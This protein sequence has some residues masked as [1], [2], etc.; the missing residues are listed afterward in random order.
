MGTTPAF[1]PIEIRNDSARFGGTMFHF[2]KRGRPEGPLLTFVGMSHPQWDADAR[3]VTKKIAWTNTDLTLVVRDIT[4]GGE[5]KE[6][7]NP[8]KQGTSIEFTPKWGHK[9]YTMYNLNRMGGTNGEASRQAMTWLS[10]ASHRQY[11][12]GLSP[13]AFETRACQGFPS[14]SAR[15]ETSSG[16]IAQVWDNGGI[17]VPLRDIDLSRGGQALTPSLAIHRLDSTYGAVVHNARTVIGFY[18]DGQM[19]L[20]HQAKPL[21]KAIKDHVDYVPTSTLTRLYKTS[22]L[23]HSMQS[24][25]RAPPGEMEQS[26]PAPPLGER[27]IRQMES[28]TGNPDAPI[29]W[30]RFFNES[31]RTRRAPNVQF[32]TTRQ[33]GP[34]HSLSFASTDP[35][36]SS[37][38]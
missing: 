19:S 29:D 5:I 7:T 13:R 20:E 21:S 9:G 26:I 25:E 6:I 17:Y 4:R 36:D 27:L 2:T 16:V 23:P 30:G 15:P 34:D 10:L 12:W 35:E 31:D 8:I 37:E 32:T 18:H 11:R 38:R 14:A 28:N 24:G 3:Q 33:A 1:T 22:I